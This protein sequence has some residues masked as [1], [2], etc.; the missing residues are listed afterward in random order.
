MRDIATI[1]NKKVP[2]NWDILP[3][4]TQYK[5]KM[6]RIWPLN[7]R[8]F[9]CHFWRSCIFIWIDHLGRLFARC[10]L[11]SN[12][13]KRVLIANEMCVFLNNFRQG[14]WICQSFNTMTFK[15]LAF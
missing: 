11:S 9:Y 12:F 10:E 2:L 13:T 1:L 8:A 3:E 15:C 6:Y 14:K 7:G 5:G 4:Y